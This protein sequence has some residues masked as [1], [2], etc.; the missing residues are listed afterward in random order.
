[1]AKMETPVVPLADVDCGFIR[2]HGVEITPVGRVLQCSKMQGFYAF[3]IEVG[4]GTRDEGLIVFI[5]QG[6]LSDLRETK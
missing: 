1:M 6:R 3:A 4:T 2:A 5:P